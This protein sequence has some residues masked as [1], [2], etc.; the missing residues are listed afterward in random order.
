MHRNLLYLGTRLLFFQGKIIL[1]VQRG[2]AFASGATTQ[3]VHPIKKS[4]EI[5]HDLAVWKYEAENYGYFIFME[6]VLPSHRGGPLK[7]QSYGDLLI[8][9]GLVHAAPAV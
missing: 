8:T 9:A 6:S 3:F 7:R 1:D 4:C 2:I 5:D